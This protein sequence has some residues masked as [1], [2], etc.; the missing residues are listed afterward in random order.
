LT[1][2]QKKALEEFR[3]ARRDQPRAGGAGSPA[4]MRGSLAGLS[5]FFCPSSQGVLSIGRRP[6]SP[7]GGCLAR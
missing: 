5:L 7:R 4:G 1:S 3:K 2:E 6:V